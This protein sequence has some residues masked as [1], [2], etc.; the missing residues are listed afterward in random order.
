VLIESS[1]KGS[2]QARRQI[3]APLIEALVDAN[4]RGVPDLPV[5]ALD[6]LA[7]AVELVH[8][9][10]RNAQ[11]LE[12]MHMPTIPDAIRSLCYIAPPASIEN[13]V[14]TMAPDKADRG[15]FPPE[16]IL[17]QWREC[18]DTSCNG[19]M[20]HNWLGVNFGSI[21]R[22]DGYRLAAMS[23]LIIKT[24]STEPYANVWLHLN[25]AAS[26]ILNNLPKAAPPRLISYLSHAGHGNGVAIVPASFAD[27]FNCSAETVR[28]NGTVSDIASAI[29]QLWN[30][31]TYT[32]HPEDALQKGFGIHHTSSHA[33][34]L[35]ELPNG[36]GSE[37]NQQILT[38]G[39]MQAAL[40]HDLVG[41]IVIAEGGG[42][43]V[44][45]MTNAISGHDGG[46]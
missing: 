18:I 14:V 44:L 11:S 34:N 12:A 35:P 20:W 27:L 15:T 37:S 6:Q 19:N 24:W 7:P 22:V 38:E 39:Q 45:L 43:S 42:D 21:E 40:R 3:P 36:W 25:P 28:A 2:A 23:P 33:A 29:A 17:N 10:Q 41:L 32:K 5:A 9:K 16:T 13:P 8:R 31:D 26:E 1:L 30:P 46:F 4:R